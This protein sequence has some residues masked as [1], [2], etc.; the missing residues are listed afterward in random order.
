[1]KNLPRPAVIEIDNHSYCSVK[2]CIA[3]FLG[4]G[5]LPA[6]Q[7]PD[8][9]KHSKYITT[10]AKLLY[11]N[12]LENVLI[13]T[14]VQWSDDFEPNSLSK[15]LRGG[16][17]IKIITFL[18]KNSELNSIRDTNLISISSKHGSHDVVEKIIFR[19][20]A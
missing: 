5:Y 8:N 2:Q 14:G 10:R 7:L 15:S 1:M 16:V 19:Q 4:K 18:S 6:S 20:V 9:T 13:M 3:D 11:G 12:D 17:W